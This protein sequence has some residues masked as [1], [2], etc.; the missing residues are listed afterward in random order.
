MHLFHFCKT[1]AK[2]SKIRRL[3]LH[4]ELDMLLIQLSI[5]E[6]KYKV[7]QEMNYTEQKEKKRYIRSSIHFS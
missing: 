5:F 6:K 3:Q 1:T 7:C 4:L 2:T